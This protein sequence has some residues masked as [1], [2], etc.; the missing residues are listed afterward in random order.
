MIPAKV[1]I[2][3]CMA[4]IALFGLVHAADPPNI[5]GTWLNGEGDGLIEITQDG[6][7]ISG[8]IKG[9]ADPSDE[10]PNADTKN[11]NPEL[12]D[13][14]LTGLQLFD[15]FEY[16]GKG[17]WK[18][19]TIYDPNSGNTYKCIVTRVDDDTLKVRGYI[20][21]SMLG[22]TETWTRVGD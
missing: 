6:T 8:V 16:K 5:S 14:P 2:P 19:G 22:R 12:R 13:R 10:R 1:K 15:G 3:A 7:G 21:V 11:P 9:P 17:R 18:G 4:L 20:G